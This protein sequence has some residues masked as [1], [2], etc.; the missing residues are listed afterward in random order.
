MQVDIPIIAA[1]DVCVITA[2]A[3]QG[4]AAD[5]ML[6]VRS[7]ERGRPGKSVGNTDGTADFNEPGLNSKTIEDLKRKGWDVNRM[8]NDGCY[9]MNAASFWM[10]S[11]LLDVHMSDAPLLARA[12]RYNSKTPQYNMQY[13]QR[14]E[15]P[16][17][18][19][20]CH[21]HHYWATPAS[22]LFAVASEVMSEKEL[23]TCKPN[24]NP[25]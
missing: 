3:N 17:R 13:Q 14:L 22:Q 11:K 24:K 23:N 12:A 15:R 1:S 16:L 18:T 5:L 4:V 20:A 10:R 8:L 25:Y 9:A 7:V 21:L 19:W 6:A 2:A